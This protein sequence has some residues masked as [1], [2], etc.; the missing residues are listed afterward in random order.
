MS[1]KQ[2]IRLVT[3]HSSRPHFVFLFVLHTFCAQLSRVCPFSPA[4]NSLR[5]NN[6]ERSA[7]S[8]RCFLEQGKSTSAAHPLEC[9]LT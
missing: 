3:S 6:Q 5:V 1:T 7:V 8:L 9:Q 2:G 4:L